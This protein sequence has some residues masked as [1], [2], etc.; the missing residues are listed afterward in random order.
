MRA[1]ESVS[2]LLFF[3]PEAYVDVCCIR[4]FNTPSTHTFTSLRHWLCSDG[5][6]ARAIS[7]GRCAPDLQG[8]W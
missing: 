7:R 6:P 2:L 1:E 8:H 5:T 3:E 4:F